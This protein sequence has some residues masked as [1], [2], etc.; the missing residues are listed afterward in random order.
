MKN[1]L[2]CFAIVAFVAS[3]SNSSSTNKKSQESYISM[4]DSLEGVKK[5]FF[6]KNEL[7]P[8]ELILKT[9]QAYRF[10]V[11]DYPNDEKAGQYLFEAAKQYEIG[12]QDY[13][14]ALRV[15]QQVYEEYESFEHHPMAL[16]HIANVYHSMND[17]E[18]A[19]A[20]FKEFKDKYPNHDFAD[21]AEGMI[22]IIEMG[23]EEEFLKR[24]MEQTKEKKDSTVG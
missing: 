18:N 2:I 3:C 9:A 5:V 4:I 11:A 19:I 7:P 23:G 14:N 17:T 15:Y 13:N 10:F 6:D 20:K 12:L 22:N 21:D 16:F 8:K 1:I 24:I